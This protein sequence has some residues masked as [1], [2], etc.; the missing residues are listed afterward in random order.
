MT[1]LSL[2]DRELSIVRFSTR[3]FMYDAL[4]RMTK[5]ALAANR[6]P[7]IEIQKFAKDASDA[8]LLLGKLDSLE[9]NIGEFYETP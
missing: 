5:L 2:T 1:D 8:A 6:A 9:D 7:P 4:D 3:R